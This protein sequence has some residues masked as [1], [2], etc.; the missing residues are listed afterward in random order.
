M[1]SLDL[2]ILIEYIQKN[3]DTDTI[4]LHNKEIFKTI[5]TLS[6]V[7]GHMETELKAKCLYLP[8][9]EWEKNH[10]IKNK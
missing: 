9:I 3:Y 5:N 6:F 1:V 2:K 4:V 7:I 8:E 10:I